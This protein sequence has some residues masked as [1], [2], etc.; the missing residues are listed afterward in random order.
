MAWGAVPMGIGFG[1][2]RWAFGTKFPM[3][4]FQTMIAIPVFF[5]IGL[6]LAGHGAPA[7]DR[8]P[9]YK[10]SF[11]VETK[12]TQIDPDE[13]KNERLLRIAKET[14]DARKLS[15][16]YDRKSSSEYQN[17]LNRTLDNI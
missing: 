11:S 16:T 13:T 8:E 9:A 14:R 17:L 4:L 3:A 6:F 5:I 1:I 7:N 10:T 15:P 12:R 2:T